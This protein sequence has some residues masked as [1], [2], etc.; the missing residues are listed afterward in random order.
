MQ[1]DRYS[2][3]VGWLKVLLPLVALV[4]L[5]TLFLFARRTGPEGDIPYA[6]IEDIAR[7]PRISAP[8]FAG[9]LPD[10][11]AVTVA[12]D[13][14]R[15]DPEAPDVL[16]ID[17]LTAGITATDGAR[18]DI[19][20]ASGRFDGRARMITLDGLARITTSDG[21]AMETTGLTADLR[22]GTVETAGAL[23]VRTPFGALDAG[24]LRIASDAAGHQ[25]MDFN[26]GVR[27]LYLPQPEGPLP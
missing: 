3:L 2:R 13:T 26:G 17:G 18:I 15:P 23:A 8:A 10:G 11:S 5:S 14:I 24:R 9:V 27:L 19:T 12:A 7:D 4:L 1:I 25:V 20:A 6:E 22:A 16:T 21:Y